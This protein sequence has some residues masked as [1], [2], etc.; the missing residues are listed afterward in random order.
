MNTPSFR[1][2]CYNLE[3]IYWQ[4]KQPKSFL[5][6]KYQKSTWVQL[7]IVWHY[8][9]DGFIYL[10]SKV[11]SK[12]GCDQDINRRISRALV[13]FARFRKYLRFRREIRLRTKVSIYKLAVLVYGVE[14]WPIKSAHGHTLEG[15]ATFA[16]GQFFPSEF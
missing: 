12:G 14:S 16:Y 5:S 13:L 7:F 10:R 8:K 4:I 6:T 2:C 15:L 1:I 9:V 3:I 11:D